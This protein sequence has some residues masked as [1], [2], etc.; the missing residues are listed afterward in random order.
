MPL[1]V[2][3]QVTTSK[4]TNPTYT[5][6]VIVIAIFMFSAVSAEFTFVGIFNLVQFF[7]F[8]FRIRIADLIDVHI[9]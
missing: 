3:V 7:V 1:G 6:I 2:Y 8:P 5:A 9:K 4:H